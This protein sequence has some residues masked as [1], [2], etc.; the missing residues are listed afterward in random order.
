MSI[1]PR[2][3]REFKD[4]KAADDEVW[5]QFVETQPYGLHQ[6]ST[7]WARFKVQHGWTAHRIQIVRGAKPVGGVQLLVRDFSWIGRLGY[8]SR[9]PVLP[10]ETAD[11]A[12]ELMQ[13]ILRVAVDE[14]LRYL[15]IQPPIGGSDF[16]P[17]LT[18]NG[19]HPIQFQV[20][21]TATVLVDVTQDPQAL[22][23][24]MRSGT[25]RSI[26]KALTSSL[27]VRLATR[28][29]FPAIQQLLAATARRQGFCPPSL[30]FLE[31]LSANFLGPRSLLVFLA[32]KDGVPVA[33]ELDIPFGDVLVSKRCGWSG[34]CPKEHPTELLV[35]AGMQWARE[36]G[37]RYYEIE[38]IHPTLADAIC[39]RQ[40]FPS[41]FERGP[42]WFKLG[43]GGVVK[44][45]PQNHGKVLSPRVSG[46]HNLAAQVL[47][48][49]GS[50]R[51][52]SDLMTGSLREYLDARGR[53]AD[54]L[55]AA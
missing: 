3:D 46:I 48:W 15:T 41:E 44:T 12:D 19:F 23:S 40:P 27:K 37:L 53:T 42:H 30:L 34:E 1:Q 36:N 35:W 17:T 10:A 29:D 31:E 52:S 6:Q 26:R 32:E 24:Q 51:L 8:V 50:H 2:R 43:F 4:S 45:L 47:A 18:S 39:R 9:G 33:C 54:Q 20:A 49:S 16:V 21:P 22:L 5:D 7:R 14:R 13:R 55:A 25:R 28:Q 38:G 11:L